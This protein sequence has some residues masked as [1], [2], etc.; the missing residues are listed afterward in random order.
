MVVARSDVTWHALSLP[1]N[2]E[3]KIY[4]VHSRT[5][6]VDLHRHGSLDSASVGQR[7]RSEREPETVGVSISRG[8]ARQVSGTDR[9]SKISVVTYICTHAD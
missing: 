8:R 9:Q 1:F 7:H 3:N 5:M 6:F 2:D 4:A